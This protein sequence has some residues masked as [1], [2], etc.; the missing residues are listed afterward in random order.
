MKKSQKMSEVAKSA[1]KV[2]GVATTNEVLDAAVEQIL[3]DIE[4][5]AKEGDLEFTI[6]RGYFGDSS[7]V[8][9]YK[10]YSHVFDYLQGEGFTVKGNKVSW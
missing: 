8:N 7:K 1:N 4:L 5:A 10:I 9:T 2:K 6:P 3:C